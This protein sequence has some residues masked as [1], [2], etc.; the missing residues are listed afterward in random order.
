MRDIKV[1]EALIFL[2]KLTGGNT[3]KAFNHGKETYYGENCGTWITKT[4]KNRCKHETN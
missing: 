1:E 2:D 4:I 3:G